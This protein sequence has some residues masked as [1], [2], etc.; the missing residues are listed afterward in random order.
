MKLSVTLA[1]FNEEANLGRCLASIKNVADELIVVDGQSGD[2]TVSIA[3]KYKA[4]IISVPNDPVNFHKQKELANN[5]ATGDWIL[6]LDADEVVTPE[7]AKEI[8]QTIDSNPA[9]NGFWIPRA[10]L[11]ASESGLCKCWK[12]SHSR[13]SWRRSPCPCCRARSWRK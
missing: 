13:C 2:K 12:A 1:V 9:E 8:T 6:Q 10:N 3:K 7:L 4:K 11:I 5:N